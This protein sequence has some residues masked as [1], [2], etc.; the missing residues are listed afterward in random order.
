M[1][2]LLSKA[3]VAKAAPQGMITL[4]GDGAVLG[5]LAKALGAALPEPLAF[6]VAGGLSLVWMSP[7]ELLLLCP[8]EDTEALLGKAQAAIGAAHGA[9]VGVS[10][11][12]VI[13][14]ITG[15]GAEKVIAKLCPFDRRGFGP[16]KVRRTRL[17]QVAG[18]VMATDTGYRVLAFRSIEDYLAKLLE[19]AAL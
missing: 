18:A 13:Y 6:T 5:K 2:D 8:P 19:T 4:R 3:E 17:A 14:D 1:F 7:D 16:G 12:R 10:D 9:A 15:P 11:A